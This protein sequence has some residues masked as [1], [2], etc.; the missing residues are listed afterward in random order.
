MKSKPERL[1]IYETQFRSERG[2][3]LN[4]ELKYLQSTFVA[5][6]LTIALFFSSTTGCRMTSCELPL[7]PSCNYQHPAPLP[8]FSFQSMCGGERYSNACGETEQLDAHPINQD[9]TDHQQATEFQPS[10]SPISTARQT[11]GEE[12][13]KAT[14]I[15][16]EKSVRNNQLEWS[17]SNK[18]FSMS[19]KQHTAIEKHLSASK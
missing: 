14:G 13:Q 7:S 11:N 10:H 3:Q 4:I 2:N 15:A 5:W 19:R 8:A 1:A 9:Q 18:P 17:R 12:I 6:T 16:S